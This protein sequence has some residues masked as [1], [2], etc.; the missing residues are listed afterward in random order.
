MCVCA[1]V[2]V[3]VCVRALRFGC[4]TVIHV[5]L[6]ILPFSA[7]QATV[8]NLVKAESED[9]LHAAKNLLADLAFVRALSMLVFFFFFLF[10]LLFYYKNL[11]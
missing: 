6:I 9:E 11:V 8:E 5:N 2:C 1:C 3:C 7:T 4:T 10:L